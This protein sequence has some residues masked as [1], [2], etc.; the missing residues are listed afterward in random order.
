MAVVDAGFVSTCASG[1]CYTEKLQEPS[2]IQHACS[3]PCC[4]IPKPRTIDILELDSARLCSWTKE[5]EESCLHD[6]SLKSPDPVCCMDLMV[7]VVLAVGVVVVVVAAV[8]AVAIVSVA[9]VVAAAV[10][11][12][13]AARTVV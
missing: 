13:G 8:A 9:A 5:G 1:A 11:V 12:A 7:V 4:I 10:A 2:M 3:L 6:F